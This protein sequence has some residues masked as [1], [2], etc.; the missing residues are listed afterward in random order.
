MNDPDPVAEVV[1]AWLA[2]ADND[3]RSAELLS[4]VGDDGPPDVVAYHAQQCVEKCLKALLVSTGVD[5][6][7]T[8]DIS[9]LVAL[10]SD[11]GIEAPALSVEEQVSL[12]TYATVT[13]YP[14][15]Y[16]PVGGEEA[17]AALEVA[18]RVRSHVRA[19]LDPKS[20]P[21]L[22]HSECPGSLPASDQDTE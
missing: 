11:S 22:R 3:L 12:T 17:L 8:H 18:R 6:P 1:R 5:Y 9:I 4:A 19:V 7:R 16:E 20:C 14:G 10:L 2:K 21:G 13:R 15:G